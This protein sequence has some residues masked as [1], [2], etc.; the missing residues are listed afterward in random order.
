MGKLLGFPRIARPT[1]NPDRGCV[2][3]WGKWGA[4]FE[5]GHESRSG[6]SWGSFQRFDEPEVAVAAAYQLA[7]VEYG[8][9]D[10]YLAP[11]VIAA[12][13]PGPEMPPLDRGDF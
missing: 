5:I 10:V 6:E 9:C 11:S 4:G 3:C 7:R 12:V 8:G 1:G 13:D 2:H